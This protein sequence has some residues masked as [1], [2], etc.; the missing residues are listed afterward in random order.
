MEHSLAGSWGDSLPQRERFINLT[1]CFLE[2][3]GTIDLIISQPALF[4]HRHLRRDAPLGLLGSETTIEQAFELL[5]GPAPC[6]HQPIEGLVK[7]GLNVQRRDDNGNVRFAG[8]LQL[9]QP[10]RD[11]LENVRMNDGVQAFDFFRVAKN[12]F[13]QLR[14]IDFSACVENSSAESADHFLGYGVFRVEVF[15]REEIGFDDDAAAFVQK[16]CDR[17]LSTGDSSGEADG[18][19]A[20]NILRSIN[21]ATWRFPARAIRAGDARPSPCCS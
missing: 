20:I 11:F 1:S 15:V 13:A 4:F 8:S 16:P 2:R 6:N 21:G 9:L 17:G 14:A 18:Q 19:H 5:L 12:D 3:P 7:T 10:A